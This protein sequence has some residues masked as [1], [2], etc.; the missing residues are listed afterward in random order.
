MSTIFLA[1]VESKFSMLLRSVGPI[2]L[3]AMVCMSAVAATPSKPVLDADRAQAA[4]VLLDGTYVSRS[5]HTQRW[6]QI[7]HHSAVGDG[8]ARHPRAS[9][10]GYGLVH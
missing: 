2:I 1:A 6:S 3:A 7:Q 5:D 9:G 4:S 10:R 8:D